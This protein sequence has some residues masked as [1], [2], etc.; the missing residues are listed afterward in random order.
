MVALGLGFGFPM[1]SGGDDDGGRCVES[2]IVGFC[3]CGIDLELAYGLGGR[4]GEDGEQ[5]GG[6]GLTD[7]WMKFVEFCCGLCVLDE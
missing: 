4:I 3:V 2:Q 7:L 6:I 1:R 5:R